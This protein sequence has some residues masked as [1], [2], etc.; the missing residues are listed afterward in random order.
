[1]SIQNNMCNVRAY[2][3]VLALI[4]CLIALSSPAYAVI[5]YDQDVT[6]E[7]IFGSGNANGGF[8]TDRAAGVELGLRAK[9]RHNSTGQP[10]NTF[11]SNGDGTYTFSAGV[12]PTQSFPTG[13]WS[14]EW[15]INSDYDG[16]SGLSLDDLTYELSMASTNSAFIPT[17]DPIHEINPGNGMVLWDH[18]IGTNATGNGAGTEA[19]NAGEYATLIA[20]NNLAQNSWKPHWY[21]TGFDPKVN[22]TYTFTLSAFDTSGQVA[23]TAIQVNVVPE[24]ATFVL[25][26]LA[27]AA[28]VGCLRRRR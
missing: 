23:S 24:P 14:F 15:S 22:G 26:G 10:E 13:V 25:L 1:M 17:F 27:S 8:T 5:A 3:T 16:S 6:N 12:A 2:F 4:G 9:L 20:G 18:S 21:A 28:G 7:V 19:G 11:N